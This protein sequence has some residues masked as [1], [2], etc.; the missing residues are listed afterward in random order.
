MERR[1]VGSTPEAVAVFL[2]PRP[3][4]ELHGIGSA[5]QRT[6]TTYGVHTIGL[7]AN[8]PEATVQR[9]LGGMDAL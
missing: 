7:L 3:V 1:A 9:V 8:L 5:Q 2:H 4:G 6:L